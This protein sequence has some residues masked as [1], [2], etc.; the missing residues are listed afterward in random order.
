MQKE[1]PATKSLNYSNK[2][3]LKNDKNSKRNRKRQQSNKFVFRG[4]HGEIAKL[5]KNAGAKE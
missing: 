5:L 3:V 1:N 2:L 4:N